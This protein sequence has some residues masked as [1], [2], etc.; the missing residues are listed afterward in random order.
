[1]QRVNLVEFAMAYECRNA[2]APTGDLL[3]ADAGL[4]GGIQ[5]RQWFQ[6]SPLCDNWIQSDIASRRGGAGLGQES[7]STSRVKELAAKR[8]SWAKPNNNTGNSSPFASVYDTMLP[9]KIAPN[10]IRKAFRR[11]VRFARRGDAYRR[12]FRDGLDRAAAEIKP[13]VMSALQ[14]AVERGWEAGIAAVEGMCTKAYAA[15]RAEAV[16]ALT[17]EALKAASEQALALAE[18]ENE[19]RDAQKH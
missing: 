2:L 16:N 8:I 3:L 14:E 12:G 15:G 4:G 11:G 18:L 19:A 10:G 17:P 6:L 13:F 9:M 1:M 7:F 5:N